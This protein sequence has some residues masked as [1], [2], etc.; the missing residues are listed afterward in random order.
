[1]FSVGVR[2]SWVSDDGDSTMYRFV[3]VSI[4]SPAL[5][6]NPR[7]V[8]LIVILIILARHLRDT[9]DRPISKRWR[10]LRFWLDSE[11]ASN[12]VPYFQVDSISKA[13]VGQNHW[14]PL[15]MTKANQ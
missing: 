5:F 10:M 3:G 7:V 11:N 6:Y 12:H 15:T 2:L 13:E 4:L 1:M 8:V 14:W 9:N